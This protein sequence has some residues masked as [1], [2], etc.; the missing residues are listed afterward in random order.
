MATGKDII[1][2]PPIAVKAAKNFPSTLYG[3]LSP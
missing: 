2:I 3:I 1:R